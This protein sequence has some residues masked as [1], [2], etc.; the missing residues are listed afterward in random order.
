MCVSVVNYAKITKGSGVYRVRRVRGQ[1]S[2]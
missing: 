2:E 1:C